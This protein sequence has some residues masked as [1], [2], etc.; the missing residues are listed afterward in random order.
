MKA[1]KT[2]ILVDTL[3][4]RIITPNNYMKSY[5][6]IQ[7]KLNEFNNEIE[8]LERLSEIGMMVES[9]INN[10][11]VFNKFQSIDHIKKVYE[12]NNKN[13]EHEYESITTFGNRKTD[14]NI[15]QCQLCGKKKMIKGRL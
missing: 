5:S 10:E 4:D 6:I 2:R 12:N 7:A 9:L 8:E 15:F 1:I 14:E 3:L 13:C 11:M